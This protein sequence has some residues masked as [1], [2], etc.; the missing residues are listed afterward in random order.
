MRKRQ[1][2]DMPIFRQ[3]DNFSPRIRAQ[4]LRNNEIVCCIVNQQSR[5]TLYKVTPDKSSIG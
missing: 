3:F 5:Q 4:R 2:S 1:M